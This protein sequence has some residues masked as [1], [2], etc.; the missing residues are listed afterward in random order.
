MA[1]FLYL[2]IK[3]QAEAERV[4]AQNRKLLAENQK[5][6]I[7]PLGLLPFLIREYQTDF[8]LTQCIFVSD[9]GKDPKHER[10]VKCHDEDAGGE[11]KLMESMSNSALECIMS[12]TNQKILQFLLDT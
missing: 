7:F 9:Q 8:D 12:Q 2:C 3:N 11:E 6:E 4:E 10:G 5:V 1:P